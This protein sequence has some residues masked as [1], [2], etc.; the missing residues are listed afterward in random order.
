MLAS[1]DI[2]TCDIS[3]MKLILLNTEPFPSTV[4]DERL[5]CRS[6]AATEKLCLQ[7]H[8]GGLIVNF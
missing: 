8:A 6:P 4:N 1:C 2:Y 3:V 7:K 5:L